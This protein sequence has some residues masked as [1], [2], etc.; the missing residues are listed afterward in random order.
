MGKGEI[1]HKKQFLLILQCFLPLWRPFHFFLQIWYCHL[2]TVWVWKHL[3]IVIWERVNLFALL[4]L[5][6]YYRQKFGRVQTESFLEDK[7]LWWRKLENLIWQWHKTLWEKEKMVV[8]S[9]FS[10]SHNIFKNFLFQGLNLS[11]ISL[12]QNWEIPTKC[13][14]N[15]V[16]RNVFEIFL[17]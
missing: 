8:P 2:Q 7:L 4:N 5:T 17:M 6:L 12:H 1:S 13:C 3:Q 9:G 14:I 15:F 16:M 10:F 11:K